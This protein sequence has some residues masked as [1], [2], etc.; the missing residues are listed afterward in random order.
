MSTL[1]SHT[2]G[3]IKP[4]DKGAMAQA[5][6]RQD[7]LTKPPGSLGRLEQLSIQL[8]GIQ[9]KPLPNINQKAIITMAADHGVVAEK[10]GN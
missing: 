3:M 6:A 1:L 7:T 9:G 10:V 8:A 2:I 4:L 5:Q